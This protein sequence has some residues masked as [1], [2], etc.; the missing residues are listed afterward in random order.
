MKKIELYEQYLE[1]GII[2]Q[3]VRQRYDE[4]VMLAERA[5]TDAKIKLDEVFHVEMASGIDKSAEKAVARKA[6]E[7]AVKNV[8]Y[9]MEER[10]VAHVHFPEA[11]GNIRNTLKGDK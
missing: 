9:A 1:Q 2:H 10:A 4:K 7:Q 5:L 6:I 3:S 11:D 8:E